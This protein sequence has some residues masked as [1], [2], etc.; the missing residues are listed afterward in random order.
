M[1]QLKQKTIDALEEKV[2]FNLADHS[3]N[4]LY[5]IQSHLNEETIESLEK[6]VTLLNEVTTYKSIE[7][8]DDVFDLADEIETNIMNAEDSLEKI[9]EFVRQVLECWPDPDEDLEDEENV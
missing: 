2:N 5:G 7:N 3:V 1:A 6:L 9:S 8:G 4:L